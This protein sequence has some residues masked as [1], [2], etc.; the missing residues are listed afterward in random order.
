VSRIPY[1]NELFK[2]V[3]NHEETTTTVMMVTPKI[4][5]SSEQEAVNAPVAS[6]GPTVIENLQKLEYVQRL[7]RKA[8]QCRRRGQQEWAAH[9]YQKIQELC[10][11]SRM[12]QMAARR[13]QQLHAAE[14]P[15]EPSPCVRGVGGLPS[16]ANYHKEAAELL[17][18]YYQACAEGHLAEA[19]QWAIRA[20][21]IDPACFS[22]EKDKKV[23]H[24]M[25]NAN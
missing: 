21:A 11:G 10:P 16:L 3:R 24:P 6:T 13:C 7:F 25:L 8:E 1:V 17:G 5:C 9:A 20:L 12:A 18:K 15:S 14:K 2:M 23:S 19:T 22:K 4:I